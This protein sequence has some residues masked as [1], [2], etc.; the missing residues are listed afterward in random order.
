VERKIEEEKE[1]QSTNNSKKESS[2]MTD[3]KKLLKQC[4]KSGITTHHAETGH[5][6]NFKEIKIVD[7][8]NNKRKLEIL[9]TL[10]IKTTKNMNKKEDS[11]VLKNVYHG[12]L[13]K[14]RKR[15]TREVPAPYNKNMTRNGTTPNNI[16]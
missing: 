11:K 15:K 8:E 1:K 14:I 6:M 12:I 7:R 9:E 13:C 10:H 2:Q 5:S 3:L 4:K 16:F